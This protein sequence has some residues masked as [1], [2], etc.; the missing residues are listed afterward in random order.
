M[1]GEGNGFSRD[2]SPTVGGAGLPT[3]T[4]VEPTPSE[5]LALG[6]LVAIKWLDHAAEPDWTVVEDL[7]NDPQ[8]IITV[9][10]PVKDTAD[11]IILAAS[12]SDTDLPKPQWVVAETV[13][14][15]KP[16]IVWVLP[17]ADIEP[18]TPKD[19]TAE[20]RDSPGRPNK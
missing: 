11:A 18:L 1:R 4:A 5:I 20:P 14:I 12:V 10:I 8:E 15:L 9:G 19:D 13:M 16:M 17:L 7:R 3:Q 6:G 2:P